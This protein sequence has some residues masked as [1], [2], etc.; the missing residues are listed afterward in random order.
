MYT[1]SMDGDRIIH[2]PRG[3]YVDT[4]VFG[5]CFDP[6]FKAESLRLFDVVRSGRLDLLVSGLVLQELSRAP[7]HVQA[8]LTSL[9]QASLVAVDI[10]RQVLDLRDAYL[11]AAILAP[12]S[13]GDAT[14]VAAATVHRAL[15]VVSWNFR[16][17]VRLDRIR[18]FNNV[19]QLL[20]FGQISIVTPREVRFDDE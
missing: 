17:L 2:K 9:P 1:Q 13:A 4:S 16:H 20:G 5:G 8:V 10:D 3:I 6:E 18:G 14:H 7:L 11:A 12:S 19:N 15:A